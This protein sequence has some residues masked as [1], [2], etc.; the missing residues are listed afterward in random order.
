M[1]IIGYIV[2]RTVVSGFSILPWPVLYSFSSVLG[3]FMN[4]ILRYRRKTIES[5]LQRVFPDLPSSNIRKIMRSYYQ[6]L[7]EIFLE[8]LKGIS[9]SA[10]EMKKR[11]TG[12]VEIY[13]YYFRKGQDVIMVTSHIGNWE[14][15]AQWV[16]KLL[17]HHCVGIYKPLSNKRIDAYLFRHR[18]KYNTELLPVKMSSEIWASQVDKP[19]C[20]ILVA[21]QSPNNM[22]KAIWVDF[23]NEKVPF[24]HGPDDMARKHNLP[25]V[26][27]LISK[28]SRGHYHLKSQVLTDHPNQSVR[29]EITQC[30]ADLLADDIRRHPA[31][32]LWSH[33]R[34]KKM[35]V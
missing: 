16:A 5:N 14:W 22:D 30:Y 7:A 24:V 31:D 19:R 18:T 28:V 1:Q 23:F 8:T 15:A 33:R 29:G 12:D 10:E 2:F 25:V 34:Y 4:H 20:I 35:T 3:G 9:M 27:S 26:Y 11:F 21:D 6:L 13:E 17:P 32:W